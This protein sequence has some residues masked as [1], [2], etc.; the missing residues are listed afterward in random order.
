MLANEYTGKSTISIQFCENHFVDAY[1]PTIENTFHK[2]LTFKGD[3]YDTEIIDTAG[4]VIFLCLLFR[5]VHICL[6][7]LHVI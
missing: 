2:K 7:Q 4:Q 6:S 3:E 5:L 1:N